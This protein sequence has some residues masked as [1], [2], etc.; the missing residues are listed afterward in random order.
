[1]ANNKDLLFEYTFVVNMDEIYLEVDKLTD[2]VLSG[3]IYRTH[4]II[5]RGLYTSYPLFEVHLCTVTF[6]FTYG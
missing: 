4:A 1:M 2:L 3:P 5:T 6:G